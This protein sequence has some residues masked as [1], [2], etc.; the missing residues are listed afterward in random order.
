M[1]RHRIIL[2]SILFLWAIAAEAA[3]T[4]STHRLQKI[5]S[6]LSRFSFDTLT[7]GTHEL[8]DGNCT[9][10]V[11]INEWQ[12]IEHI[13]LKIFNPQNIDMQQQVVFDFVGR[14]V[15]ELQMIGDMEMAQNRMNN[16]NVRIE[17]GDLSDFFTLKETDDFYLSS[18]GFKGYKMAWSRSNT[19]F[20]DLSFPMDYQLMS[21]CN[22]IELENNFIRDI[23]RYAN[24]GLPVNANV[25]NEI[26]FIS[27][28]IEGK[29]YVHEGGSFLSGAIRHDLYYEGDTMGWSLLCSGQKPYWSAY[30]IA[31]SNV[32]VGDF[33]LDGL[34]D[35]F[36][37]ETEPFT[38]SFY[39]WVAFCEKGGGI[40]Y[41][42]IKTKN[43]TCISG[44]VFVS[45]ET[46]GFCHMMTVEIPLSAIEN[47]GGDINGRMFVYVPMHNVHDDYFK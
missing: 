37:Y 39:K 36:G 22:A 46:K 9:L 14:Y 18:L 31:L 2:V 19:V 24:Q 33:C 5:A 28:S 34:L 17:I 27:D 38:I 7:C 10:V 15:L 44:T 40:L 30:N 32:P 3:N 42:G 26:T 25:S 35:K 13:G 47:R 11:R 21:G 16:D 4:Y 45:Y 8:S 12:E 1:K 29:Y 41:F 23:E 43:E 6:G 20:L